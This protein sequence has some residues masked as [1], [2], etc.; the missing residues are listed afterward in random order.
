M[1]SFINISD[2]TL[3]DYWR[4]VILFGR[5]VASYKFALAQSLLEL[6]PTGKTF[7][8]LS[9]LAEPFSRHLCHHLQQ[10]DVQTTSKSS[11]FLN[12]CREYNN[13]KISQ[14]E[15]LD[16]TVRLGFNNVI[17]AFH[18]VNRGELPERFFSDEREGTNKGIALTDN[19]FRLLENPEISA[20]SQE[21]EARWKL[22]ETAWDLGL[23]RQVVQVSMLGDRLII[24]DRRRDVT[25]CRD[26]LNGYQKAQCFYC[27]TDISI[28]P[29]T[30]NLADIDH[31][32]P[33]TLSQYGIAHP[34]DGVWNLVLACQQCNRGVNGKFD[35]LPAQL[36]LERLCDRN[37]FLIESHH[38]LKET[39][40]AQTG[41]T[42]RQRIQ[43][44]Q[45]NYDAARTGPLLNSS[46]KAPIRGI[47]RF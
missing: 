25:S 20:F 44:L 3:E 21:V 27:Y 37:E 9:E 8:S 46:W 22:V 31:V 42:K 38:P 15:L 17:D 32:F 1:T 23:S 6:A 4:G 43:F 11:R 39:L 29:A 13:N 28:D 2:P 24:P 34:I 19:L 16:S 18:N 14:E 35:H 7:I 40:I 10:C 36:Y 5:N 41:R 45:K 26:A 47:P 12:V 33:H 30:A